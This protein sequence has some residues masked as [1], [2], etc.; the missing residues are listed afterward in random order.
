MWLPSSDKL[1][2]WTETRAAASPRLRPLS[3]SRTVVPKPC[4]SLISPLFRMANIVR[5]SWRIGD[6]H[7][8]PRPL[9]QILPR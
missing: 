3:T 1:S 5:P 9:K 2:L 8:R 4:Q 6:A 7:K